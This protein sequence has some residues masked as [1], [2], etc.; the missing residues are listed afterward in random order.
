[1][2]ESVVPWDSSSDAFSNALLKRIRTSF[3]KWLIGFSLDV[4][5]ALEVN[6]GE[7]GEPFKVTLR[8]P[9]ST[10]VTQATLS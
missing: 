9:K 7:S 2:A 3:A 4:V 5:L 10:R 6:R 8:D 1:M